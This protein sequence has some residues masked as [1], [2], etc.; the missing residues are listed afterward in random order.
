MVERTGEDLTTRMGRFAAACVVE[1][2]RLGLDGYVLKSGSPSCGL[3]GVRV[4]DGRDRVAG[5]G[6]GLFAA[7][8][9]DGLPALPVEEEGRLADPAVRQDFLA[10]AFARRRARGS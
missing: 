9:V 3:V 2:A 4:H 7:A 1:L 6:R 10:R 8:L 5:A